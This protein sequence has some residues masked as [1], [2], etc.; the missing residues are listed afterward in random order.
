MTTSFRF[1]VILGLLI[2]CGV[3][4]SIFR[5]EGTPPSIELASPILVGKTGADVSIQVSDEGSGWREVRVILEHADGEMP[6]LAI[7]STGGLIFGSQATT[8]GNTFAVKIDPAALK[9]RDGDAFLNVTA[10]DWSWRNF[11]S[12][13]E[14]QS[15]VPVLVDLTSP[16]IVVESG[17]TYVKRGGAAAV[18]YTIGELTRR[19]GVEVE[20]HFY[21][22]YPV[23]EGGRRVAVFAV[24]ENGTSDPSIRV[25]AEDLVGNTTDARWAS[26]VQERDFPKVPIRLPARFLERKVP[27]LAA[28]LGMNADDPVAA[29][30]AINSETRSQNEA[31]IAEL[32]QNTEP[33]KLWNG[34]F[35]Q[36]RNS[37]V[38]SRFAERR[39][40]LF[41]G[42]KVSQAT[43][44]GYDLA[45]TA[46]APVTAANDGKVLFADDLGIYGGCVLIDHGL[47]V[48]SLYGH[49]ARIDVKAGDSVLRGAEL[50]TTGETGL[51]GGD[52][53]HFAILVGGT[54]VDPLEWWDPK[55][56]RERIE[57]RIGVPAP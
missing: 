10:R 40:Y 11:F 30:Q 22:G 50:G 24:P 57:A 44:Y 7:E 6:L 45:S 2:L 13:N 51:A 5:C 37:K 56:M 55:W 17:L 29:F 3:A 54:Y 19:D 48:V 31:R 38:T 36:L 32:I 28:H 14:Q 34:V 42:K 4:L 53:L 39:S 47:G 49:L 18:T 23:D 25:V 16:R 41:D 20:D 52:H 15:R 27:E 35:H 46:G 12:G 26:R 21:R 43:H 9:L 1:L 33:T 8:A